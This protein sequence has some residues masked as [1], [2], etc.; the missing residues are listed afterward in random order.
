[1]EPGQFAVLSIAMLALLPVGL[2][3]TVNAVS[4][5]IVVNP[6]WLGLAGVLVLGAVHGGSVVGAGL[7]VASRDYELGRLWGE[8]VTGPVALPFLLYAWLALRFRQRARGVAPRWA[9]LQALGLVAV[10]LLLSAV[11]VVTL[12]PALQRRSAAVQAEH[13]GA[14]RASFM[15]AVVA[16]LTPTLPRA[17]DPETE[18]TGVA[19]EGDLLVYDYRLLH[20]LKEELDPHAVE[21]FRAGVVAHACEKPAAR[22]LFDTGASLRHRYFDRARAFVFAVE[23]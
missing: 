12:G 11:A 20:A 15:R 9:F 16:E 17:I 10:L 19:V 18:L 14:A 8:R 5:R 7:L 22:R 1:M 6:W 21:S 3:F 4:R 13:R 2:G 23:V